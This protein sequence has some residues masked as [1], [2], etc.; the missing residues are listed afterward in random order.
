MAKE[1]PKN[2]SSARI[3]LTI[4]SDCYRIISA[5]TSGVKTPDKNVRPV[6]SALA[7]FFAKLRLASLKIKSKCL[8]IREDRGGLPNVVVA[9]LGLFLLAATLANVRRQ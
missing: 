1:W 9:A 7:I 8:G 2:V 6:A 3:F 5:E 4:S